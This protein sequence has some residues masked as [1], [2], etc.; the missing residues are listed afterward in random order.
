MPDFDQYI[1]E[2][3]NFYARPILVSLW[4]QF[5]DEGF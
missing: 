1:L 2:D 4:L 5:D 3:S